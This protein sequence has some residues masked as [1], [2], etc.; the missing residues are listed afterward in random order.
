LHRIQWIDESIR[1]GKYP[2]V[3]EVADRFEISRRQA[4][5]DV[6][7]LRDSLGAPLAY[8][9]KAKGYCYTDTAFA[10]PSQLL[11]E[12]QRDLLSCLAAH[13]EVISRIDTRTSSTFGDLAD[14]LA[15]LSGRPSP[16]LKLEHAAGD[17]VTPFRAVLRKEGARTI[18]G[19]GAGFGG[20]GGAAG[21]PTS[22]Q[23][24]YRGRSERMEEVFEFY[25]SHDF[26]PALLA[27]GMHY[28]VVHPKWLRGKLAQ[29][30]DRM[31]QSLLG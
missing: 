13:Y 19:V 28:Q 3:Q 16:A 12:S 11:T 6:E 31:R 5:R 22:L 7:Y 18:T 26:I 1:T 20:I 27:A 2:N 17:G 4:L 14:L 9:A 25:D 23:P 15:R 21:V 24:F 8:C 29:Y 30:L 10:V